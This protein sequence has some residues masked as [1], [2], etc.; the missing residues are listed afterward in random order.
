MQS[1]FI[2]TDLMK[3]GDHQTLDKFIQSHTL[4]DQQFTLSGEY[5]TLPNYDLE[6]FDRLFC[7]IDSRAANNRL[8]SNPE[9]VQELERRVQLLHSQGFKFI[10]SN[11]WESM[12]NVTQDSL[13]YPKQIKYESLFWTGGVSFFWF[14]MYDK[15]Y[16]KRDKFT[17]WSWEIDKPFDF[18]YLNKTPRPHRDNLWR[19]MSNAGLLGN[20]LTS[21]IG[22][23]KPVRLPPEYEL[24]WVDTKNYPYRGM[25]QDLYEKPYN[26]SKYSLISESNDTDNEIFMTEKIWKPILAQQVFVV[27]G[28]YLYLQKLREMGFKTFGQY[29]DEAY[30]LERDPNRRIES[31]VNLCKDLLNKNWKDIYLAS[32]GLRKHN[33]D[34]FWNKEKLGEQINSV[35]IDFIEFADGS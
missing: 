19:E 18:L 23:D 25:D 7:I 35:L 1:N 9:F 32:Q 11:P 28:N 15:H 14:Y 31:I 34:T 30:D 27:H 16:E 26:E 33:Y 5:Y 13:V 3:T 17:H 2:L 6:S 24:P 22:L 29:F 21:Y 4:P 12:Y 8:S 10:L 20:S